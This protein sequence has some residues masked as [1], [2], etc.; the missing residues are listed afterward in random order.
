V[1]IKPRL[2]ESGLAQHEAFH[3]LSPAF[4]QLIGSDDKDQA[5]RLP[6]VGYAGH[7]KGEKAEN[8]F[9]KNY[10]QTTILAT[11]NLRK[12]LTKPTAAK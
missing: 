1:Q 2:L 5:M 10:R 11:Q 6:I 7:R 9:A 12:T 4:K 8:M 3:D